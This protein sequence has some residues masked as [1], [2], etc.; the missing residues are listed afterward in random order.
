MGLGSGT[1]TPTRSYAMA[2]TVPAMLLVIV[3]V[4]TSDCCPGPRWL[5]LFAVSECRRDAGSIS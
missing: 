1:I 2:F 5:T 3:P 4:I